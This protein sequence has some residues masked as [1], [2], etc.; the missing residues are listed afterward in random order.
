[1]KRALFLILPLLFISS[2]EQGNNPPIVDTE[3]YSF[4]LVYDN[5]KG[6]VNGTVSGEYNK[7]TIISLNS[8]GINGNSFNGYYENNVKVSATAYYEFSLTKNTTVEVQFG[9]PIFVDPPDPN[10]LPTTKEEAIFT[11]TPGK[12]EVPNT[13]YELKSLSEYYKGIDLSLGGEKLRKE[14][15]KVTSLKTSRDYGFARYALQ[16]TD[17]SM[18][19]KGKLYGIYDGKSIGPKWDSGST[20]NREHLWCQSRLE[21]L[22][23]QE[24]QAKN[25]LHN[26]RASSSSTNG[27]RGNK[28][29]DEKGTSSGYFPNENNKGLDYRGDVARE[30]FYMYTNYDGL[31]LTDTPDVSLNISMGKKTVLLKWH[32][33]DPVDLFE[34]Q[35]NMKIYQYQGNRNPFIDIPELVSQLFI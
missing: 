7:N 30:I 25:D 20:W 15:Q 13:K 5:T 16:Y 21:G 2:C 1:M 14:L 9:D 32:L 8:F 31:K 28:Y 18:I 24:S 27:S 22:G 12:G 29:Y 35:R 3:K 11:L 4:T 19:D 10:E 26:L 6:V 34:T 33:E 23:S 17:E